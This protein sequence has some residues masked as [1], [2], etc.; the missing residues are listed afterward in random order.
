VNPNDICADCGLRRDAFAHQEGQPAIPMPRTGFCDFK[1]ED[2]EETY[3]R[4]WYE[5]N[6]NES[7][8]SS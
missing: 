7:S 6:N 2:I 5:M 3:M 1:E 8:N 4:E